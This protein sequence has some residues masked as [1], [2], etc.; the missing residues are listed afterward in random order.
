MKTCITCRHFRPGMLL[1][2]MM[3]YHDRCMRPTGTTTDPVHGE[4]VVLLD[5]QALKERRPGKAGIFHR[6]DRCGPDATYWAE[7]PTTPPSRPSR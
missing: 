4:Q 1:R 5:A 7:R 3:Q 2:S 6:R